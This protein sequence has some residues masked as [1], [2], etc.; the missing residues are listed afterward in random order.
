MK[1][2]FDD[3]IEKIPKNVH[4]NTRTFIGKNVAVF[5]PD[6]YVIEKG[7]I[8]A[9]YHFVIFHNTP[10][11][12]IINNKEYQL[13]SGTLLCMAPGTE[14]IVKSVRNKSQAKYV[15]ISIKD[16][17][18]ENVLTKIGG[19]KKIKPIIHD[20]HYSYKT[21][22][23]LEFFMQEFIY[24]GSPSELMIESIETQIVIQLLRD[25][26]LDPIAKKINRSQEK[27]YVE[28]AIR[29]IESYYN[30]N[31]TINEICNIIYISPCHFQRIFK[32]ATN[33]TPYQYITEFR[34]NKSKEKLN[35]ENTS[36]AEI[37]RLCGFLS[38]GHFSTVFKKNE[39]QTPSQY[40]NSLKLRVKEE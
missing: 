40:R 10:P 8:H 9:D 14:M 1:S 21:L 31:I 12:A 17:F 13:K 25:M 6:T 39:G 4:N 20:N 24:L 11:F 28:Q 15:A 32:N 38:S 22:D 2:R 30:S 3:F 29:Y 23:L 27:S 36:I 34:I 16:D 37:A 5:I 33:K 19:N 18:L 7:I 26:D 35:E